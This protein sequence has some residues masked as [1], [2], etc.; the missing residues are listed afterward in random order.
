[1]WNYNRRSAAAAAMCLL[2]SGCGAE[3][4][5]NPIAPQ[6]A[7]AEVIG[8]ARDITTILHAD[9]TEARFRYESC[10]DQG[11]PPFKGV[12]RMSFWMPGHPHSQPVDPQDVIKPLVAQGWSTDS[13][14]V[15]HSPTLRKNNINIIL[16]VIPA[17]RPGKQL[18]S[19]VAVEVDGECRDTFDHRTDRSILPI[20]VQTEVQPG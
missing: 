9:V 12:V 20:D 7:R 19:H 13:D 15:S 4:V 10:N 14:F 6:D 18:V 2:L 5:G 11:D 1:V 3:V 17:P 16:T 8:A